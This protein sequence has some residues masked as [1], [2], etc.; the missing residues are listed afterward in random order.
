MQY[1]ACIYSYSSNSHSQSIHL[2]LR[3][4]A[5]QLEVC[6]RSLWQLLVPVDRAET[7]IGHCGGM[8]SSWLTLCA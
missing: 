7:V 2:V 4:T 8:T 3:V 1:L 5:A 6:W